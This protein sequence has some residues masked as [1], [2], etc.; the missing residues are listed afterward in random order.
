MTEQKRSGSAWPEPPAFFTRYT[1]D[2]LEIARLLKHKKVDPSDVRLDFPPELLDPPSPIE[3]SY[4]VF[5]QHWQLLRSLMAQF[6]TL[7]DI[8]V[9]EP[10]KFGPRIEDISNILINIHHILNE[11]RPHQARET[12]RLMLETQLKKKMQATAEL[13]R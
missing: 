4:V 11:Y 13:K 8:L 1:D 5:D 10:E 7:L 12:L 6:L 3:G 9:R 2:N